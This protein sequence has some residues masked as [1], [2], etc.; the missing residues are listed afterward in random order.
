M[1]KCSCGLIK[2]EENKDLFPKD[3]NLCKVCNRERLRLYYIKNKEEISKRKKLYRE[4]NGIKY[5]DL[6]SS[7]KEK[8]NR[9]CKESN[10]KR[11]ANDNLYRLR[12]NLRCCIGRVFRDKNITKK[13]KTFD[14]LGCDFETFK[15]HIESKFENWMNWDNYGV[16]KGQDIIPNK[17]WDIDHIIPICTAESEYDAI[18]LNHYTNLQPLCSYENRVI[19]RDRL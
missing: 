17:T 6:P 14:I 4:I 19:K 8:R 10:R 16:P 3:G 2:T 7:E 15:L 18:R 13:S 12:E 5:K 11:R 9:F 1:L